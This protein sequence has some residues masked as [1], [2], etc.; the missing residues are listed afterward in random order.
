MKKIFSLLLIA[1]MILSLC[2]CGG[3]DNSSDN[4]KKTETLTL[5]NINSYLDVNAKVESCTTNKGELMLKY[6]M[7]RGDAEILI[8][9]QNDSGAKFKNATITCEVTITGA[10]NYGWEFV[11]GNIPSENRGT[12]KVDCNNNSK[13]VKIDLSNDGEESISEKLKLALYTDENHVMASDLTGTQ[14]KVKIVDVV[15]TVEIEE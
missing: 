4:S 10:G 3:G 2:A 9:T 7:N 5:D 1:T 6:A 13:R 15:G 8:E 12:S 11:N 14:I